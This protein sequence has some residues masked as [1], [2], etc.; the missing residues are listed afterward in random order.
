M[1]ETY[2]PDPAGSD[3]IIETTSQNVFQRMGGA[4]AGAGIGV[5]LFLVAIG[6]L[7]WNESRAIDAIRGLRQ[8]AHDAVEANPTPIS[9][10]QNGRLIHLTG[11]LVVHDTLSDPEMGLT[12]TGLI[13]LKRSV[14]MYQ[15]E[16]HKDTRSSSQVG[17]TQTTQT[18]YTYSK[19]WSEDPIDSGGFKGNHVNPDMA[20]RTQV[21]TSSDTTMGD[22]KLTTKLLDELDNYSTVPPPA[23]VPD[24]YRRD[25]GTFYRG[26]DADAPAIGDIR[27]TFAGVP[28]QTVSVLAQQR[29]T[30]LTPFKTA[31]GY[32]VG[33]VVPGDVD[34]DDMVAHKQS[35]EKILT[36]ILRGVGLLCF[37][38]ALLL[39]A[40]PVEIVADILPFV[41]SIVGGGIFFFAVMLSIPL[42]LVTIALSWVLVRPFI[43]IGLVAAAIAVV[44]AFRRLRRPRARAA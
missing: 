23:A 5:I 1:S 15:W 43:G 19:K 14:E 16:E 30:A 34:A 12:K 26:R 8:A 4:L 11:A 28:A 20:I 37:F 25:G 17:G 27:I 2:S 35:E 41:G 7:V 38:F 39:L 10:A 22:R 18:T 33:L 9:A 36:W 31:S 24:G 44:L 13:H 6:V 32:K 42:T 21:F 40:S 3:R 29:E